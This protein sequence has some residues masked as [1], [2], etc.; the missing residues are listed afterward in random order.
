MTNTGIV[1]IG[2]KRV[3]VARE[4]IR[5]LKYIMAE[6]GII[7][8]LDDVALDDVAFSD[9][10]AAA[11]WMEKTHPGRMHEVKVD[12]HLNPDFG[13]GHRGR[14]EFQEL[15]IPDIYQIDYLSLTQLDNEEAEFLG[16][17]LYGPEY[18]VNI[19]EKVLLRPENS[20]QVK[21][22]GEGQLIWH[23]GDDIR[24][25]QPAQNLWQRVMDL[26]FKLFPS[27]YF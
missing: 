21:L 5:K 23:A 2:G 12:G 14:F 4:D 6:L 20:W 26:F 25:R 19:K 9:T 11:E 17:L 22:N 1:D 24:T 8:I 13:C 3:E 10:C 7:H 18:C 15:I 27:Q 16:D